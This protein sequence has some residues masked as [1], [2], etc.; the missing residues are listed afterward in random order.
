LS[1]TGEKQSTNFIFY[2][3]FCRKYPIIASGVSAIPFPFASA[4]KFPTMASRSSFE[5]R[6]LI[7]PLLRIS[8]MGMRN[9]SFFI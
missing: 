8:L 4:L 9:S 3:I 1:P 6:S 7:Q 5:K 2:F